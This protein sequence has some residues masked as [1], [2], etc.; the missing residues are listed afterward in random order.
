MVRIHIRLQTELHVTSLLMTVVALDQPRVVSRVLRALCRASPSVAF[1]A[2]RLKKIRVSVFL[3]LIFNTSLVPV[4]EDVLI[5][6]GVIAGLAVLAT[7]A[8]KSAAA[9][10]TLVTPSAL[11]ATSTTALSTSTLLASVET[12]TIAL[13]STLGSASEPA[14]ISLDIAATISELYHFS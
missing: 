12:I 5:E 9:S 10:A 11:E 2:L 3:T 1:S 4:V 6:G 8:T 14:T 13:E 7:T